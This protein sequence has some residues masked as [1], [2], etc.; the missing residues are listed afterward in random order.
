MAATEP[1]VAKRITTAKVIEN[2]EVLDGKYSILR[3]IG[4]GAMGVVYEAR[5]LVLGT[6]VAVKVIAS[7]FVA[8]DARARFERE[9][10]AAAKIRS[11]YAVRVF[12]VG[13]TEDDDLYMVMEL[14]HGVDLATELRQGA[15]M[16]T[17][18]SVDRLLEI[19][20]A[21]ADAHKQ[22]I[23]HRDIKASNVFLSEEGEFR[24]AKLL[25]FGI[26]LDL[27]SEFGLEANLTIGT[28]RYM[29][30]E[31]CVTPDKVSARSDVWSLGVL[32]YRMLAR[33][34]PFAPRKS[35]APGT[36]EFVPPV[37]LNAACPSIP[38]DLADAVMMCLEEDPKK[39]PE[40]A[41]A[42]ALAIAPFGS[43]E[44][45]VQ[46][47]LRV[48]ESVRPEARRERESAM[49]R[50]ATPPAMLISIPRW[51]PESDKALSTLATSLRSSPQSVDDVL[52]AT[53]NVHVSIEEFPMSTK[54]D[55]PAARN[56]WKSR[57]SANSEVSGRM[58]AVLF[59]VTAASLALLFVSARFLGV[60]DAPRNAGA[61]GPRSFEPTE[62]VRFHVE[63]VARNVVLVT[64]TDDP[65]AAASER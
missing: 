13:T 38:Q 64:G 2:G 50:D 26:A 27:S 25:D 65:A 4:S 23:V 56:D 11:P 15:P 47:S 9:A 35:L 39:R 37:P 51:N 60:V 62:S 5:H 61:S 59:A 49:P 12:D 22:G 8:P 19:S 30:P 31:Q 43:G 44:V 63:A 54:A 36:F 45:P 42:F 58:K 17:A 46:R 20:C 14:L 21:L 18:E 33:R 16:S 41:A 1:I 53:G 34:Y 55:A 10:R 28:P 29:S 32:A 52:V 6:H 7:T 57:R 40:N 3:R 48:V 24:V